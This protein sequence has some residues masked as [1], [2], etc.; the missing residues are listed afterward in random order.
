MKIIISGTPG[1]GKTEV[2]KILSDIL[3]Y[4]LIRIN[5]FARDKDIIIGTDKERR[6]DIID[7]NRLQKM[8]EDIPDNTVIEGH[9]A[10]YCKADTAIILRTDPSVLKKRLKRRRWPKKKIRE[11]IE[12]EILDII[13]QESAALNKNTY[14]VDTTKKTAHDAAEEIISIL[15]S[16]SSKKAHLPGRIN[17]G[18]YME[19][20]EPH[21]KNKYK[22]HNLF[23]S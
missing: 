5:E 10:H 9:L 8:S 17:W 13:L 3:G 1:T 21:A 11:N 19:S 4:K 23:K 16:G 18:R 15:K 2:S 22:D 14:E 12:S 7:E 6:S 20:L